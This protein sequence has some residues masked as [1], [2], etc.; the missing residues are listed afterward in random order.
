[1]GRLSE[2]LGCRT[3]LVTGASS[4]LG[5]AFAR[6]LRDEG[7][8]VWGASRAPEETA[9]SEGWHAVR[10]DLT[11]TES[12]LAAVEQVRREAGV[13]DI[14]INN[15]GAGVFSSFANF[16]RE[17]ISRQLQLLLEAPIA[18]TRAFWPDMLARKSGAVVNVSSLAAEF[19]LP[20]MSL[21]SAG[22]AGLSG[23]SRALMLEAA[24]RGVQVLDFQPGDFQTAFNR[25]AV[26][27]PGGEDWEIKLWE[28]NQALLEGGA[29][30]A[31]AA[32]DLRRALA[33]R[34]SGTV[35]SGQIFQATI[36][37]L[38]QRLAGYRLTRWALLKYY[39][40]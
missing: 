39:R 24:G 33:R 5:L 34:R 35:A 38:A 13:P 6:M 18:L 3:A 21:Y 1:M 19:P 7:L 8:E 32:R 22:K 10:M 11:Q 25:A 15:A 30:P 37:P 40:M 17:Q 31:Q 27:P 9:K 26:R 28:R 16:P 4:G 23:F 20:A 36:A 12:L 29:L 2:Q 14:L